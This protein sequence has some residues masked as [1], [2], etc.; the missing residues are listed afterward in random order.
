MP[1]YTDIYEEEAATAYEEIK[2]SLKPKDGFVHIIL[3]SSLHQIK[4][5][6]LCCDHKYTTQI[7]YFLQRL[8]MSSIKLSAI[9]CALKTT[10]DFNA[11]VA[12]SS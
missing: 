6:L 11:F 9:V 4:L 7:N 3:L 12:N 10:E 2:A 1:K 5:K 8:F